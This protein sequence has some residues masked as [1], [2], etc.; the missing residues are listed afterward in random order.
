MFP[1]HNNKTTKPDSSMGPLYP[2]TIVLH[3]LT[4]PPDTPS[5]QK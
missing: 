5:V 4:W 3:S 2:S 1:A